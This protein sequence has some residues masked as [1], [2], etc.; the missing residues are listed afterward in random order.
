[1]ILKNKFELL[2]DDLARFGIGKMQCFGDSMLPL[3]YSGAY[4]TFQPAKSY[5]LGDMVFC[6]VDG[7]FIDAHKI[8]AISPVN[9]YLIADNHGNINGWTTEIYGKVIK[10]E[11]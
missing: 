7:Y 10:I 4:L 11:Y 2:R 6:L 9:G 5:Y 1:M 8:I 3:I